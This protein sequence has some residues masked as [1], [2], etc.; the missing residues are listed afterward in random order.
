[1][2]SVNYLFPVSDMCRSEAHTLTERQWN[3]DG[4]EKEL[5]GKNVGVSQVVECKSDHCH[6]AESSTERRSSK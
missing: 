6:Q 5:K 4:C 2:T 3:S 1:L